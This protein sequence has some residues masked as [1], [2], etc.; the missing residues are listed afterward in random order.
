MYGPNAMSAYSSVFGASR[1]HTCKHP[2]TTCVS[3]DYSEVGVE[4]SYSIHVD[5]ILQVDH[6]LIDACFK[7]FPSEAI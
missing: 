2:Y 6:D 3:N 4:I 5:T 7:V 1:P